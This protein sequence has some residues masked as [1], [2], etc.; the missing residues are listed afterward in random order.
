MK[1]KVVGYIYLIFY[2]LFRLNRHLL[3][4]NFGALQDMKI[5]LVYIHWNIVHKQDLHG[6]ALS[7]HIEPRIIHDKHQVTVIL[8]LSFITQLKL[9]Q[10]TW[11]HK[12]LPL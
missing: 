8:Y 11:R 12:M 1:F 10:Q 4:M 5:E 3:F 9:T 6:L 2:G 7:L